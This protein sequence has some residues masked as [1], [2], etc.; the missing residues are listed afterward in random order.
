[1]NEQME[2]FP[3]KVTWEGQ[4][5]KCSWVNHRQV[6]LASDPTTICLIGMASFRKLLASGEIV[7]EATGT[8]AN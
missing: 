2:A 4:S 5:W 8:S 3:K 1:M 7:I 6:R